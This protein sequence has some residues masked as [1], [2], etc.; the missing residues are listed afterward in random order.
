MMHVNSLSPSLVAKPS[1]KSS[2]IYIYIFI[3]SMIYYSSYVTGL[4]PP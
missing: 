4:M 1:T 3:T 2:Y